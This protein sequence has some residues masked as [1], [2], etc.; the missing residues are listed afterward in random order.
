MGVLKVSNPQWKS[1]QKIVDANVAACF[2]N[3]RSGVAL[4]N[5][6]DAHTSVALKIN[7]WKYVK[8]SQQRKKELEAGD[9]MCN[10]LILIA[11]WI[12]M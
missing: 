10:H 3:V 4:Q 6:T 9:I 11:N 5:I 8:R 7:Y 1:D 12:K 2:S